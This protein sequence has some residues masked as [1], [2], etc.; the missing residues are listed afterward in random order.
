VAAA[1]VTPKQVRGVVIDAEG[2]PWT[3]RLIQSTGTMPRPTT[4]TN[5]YSELGS[6]LGPVSGLSC[7]RVGGPE[8]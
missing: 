5:L 8:L 6:N 4:L 2:T 7:A 1:C 3:F